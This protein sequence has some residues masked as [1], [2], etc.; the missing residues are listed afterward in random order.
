M[1]FDWGLVTGGWSSAR[2]W[3]AE[4]SALA[5]S[6]AVVSSADIR[7]GLRWRMAAERGAS[8]LTA[9][10]GGWRRA[11]RSTS[12]SGEVT[13]AAVCAASSGNDDRA[14]DGSTGVGPS[15]RAGGGAAGSSRP[16]RG[17]SRP[18][19]GA[20][21]RFGETGAAASRIG[22]ASR[23]GAGG[24]EGHASSAS[25]R[26]SPPSAENACLPGTGPFAAKPVPLR[27]MPAR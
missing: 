20:A 25:P 6:E 3:I 24:P 27:A 8:G 4:E 11:V 5:G 14:V 10:A 16:T 22:A 17:A 26:L 23:P 19:A 18:S 2:S 12:L 7:A 21:V 9:S 1:I 13:G 15:R